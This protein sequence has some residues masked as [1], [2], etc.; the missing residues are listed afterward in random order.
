MNALECLLLRN[1]RETEKGKKVANRLTR[2]VPVPHMTPDEQRKWLKDMY[3]LR[4]RAT[5]EGLSVEQDL[6]VEALQPVVTRALWKGL[7]HLTPMHRAD[8]QPCRSF[9]EVNDPALHEDS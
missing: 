3:A 1:M 5:H 4:S 8:G 9:D 2:L 6:Q 7:N